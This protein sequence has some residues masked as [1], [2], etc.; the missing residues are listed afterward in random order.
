MKLIIKL[1]TI[2]FFILQFS[3]L[4]V[5]ATPS[6]TGTGSGTTT[7][8]TS[9]SQTIER[10]DILGGEF[11]P[12]NFQA[13]FGQQIQTIEEDTNQYLEAKEIAGINFGLHI[14][15]FQ[16]DV[17]T[18]PKIQ[19][20]KDY[21]RIS[22]NKTYEGNITD[23]INANNNT[24]Y[25]HLRSTNIFDLN[26]NQSQLYLAETVTRAIINPFPDPKLNELFNDKKSFDDSKKQQ[27]AADLIANQAPLTL[28]E[29]TFYNIIAKRN[30]LQI[31]NQE[32]SM[33]K[34]IHDESIRRLSSD[35]IDNTKNL[36]LKHLILELLQI[37]SFKIWMK[38]NQYT[39]NERIEA[40]LAALLAIQNNNMQK[41]T[42]TLEEAI[43]N[44]KQAT[45]DA[46]KKLPEAANMN[47]LNFNK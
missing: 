3:I 13:H 36:S 11:Q 21:L 44:N 30:P 39:Q 22:C 2:L 33:M 5:N 38:Y 9:T 40:L 37:E 19:F 7:T 8:T 20:L 27:A 12:S 6:N 23:C 34:L 4:K 42:S 35:W 14:V 26:Q 25:G 29:N 10:D 47:N 46:E 41:L 17:I 16:G 45:A 24:L 15:N 1:Y 31:N 18:D 43:Q 28:A 32:I